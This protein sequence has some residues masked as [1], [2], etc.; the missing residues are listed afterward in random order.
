MREDN[1]QTA[2]NLEGNIDLDSQLLTLTEILLVG[3]ERY[4]PVVLDDST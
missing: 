4:E 3:L 2:K 1:S